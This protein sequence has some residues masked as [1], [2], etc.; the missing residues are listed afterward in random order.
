MMDRFDIGVCVN[1]KAP[2]SH[3]FHG[4]FCEQEETSERAVWND[5]DETHKVHLEIII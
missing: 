4:I 2:L 1:K 3:S 5:K